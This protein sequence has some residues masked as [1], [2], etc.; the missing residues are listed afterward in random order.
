[1][2]NQ[3]ERDP[4]D[5]I[6]T[7]HASEGTD[8][9]RQEYQR[10]PDVRSA[11]GLGLAYLFQRAYLEAEEH[12]DLFNAN[13]PKG[14]QQLY[15]MAGC[16]KWALGK[17]TDAAAYW[18]EGVGC[19]YGDGIGNL[20]SAL[21]VFFAA[22]RRPDIVSLQAAKTLV[23][24]GLK[25]AQYR[26]EW[27]GP[28]GHFL[29][30]NMSENE[31]KDLSAGVHEADTRDR[32]FQQQFYRGV[33]KFWHGNPQGYLEDLGVC[34]AAADQEYSEEFYLARFEVDC[35]FERLS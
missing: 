18:K 5:L 12:F 1:M 15:G 32:V 30:G 33:V 28:I 9:F 3:A 26:A 24:G 7:G 27:P 25:R 8:L 22:V 13:N 29:L 21:L 16:V 34:A 31:L 19:A 2:T 6:R 4:W 23:T 17:H 11:L 35:E 20:G 10:R 14:Y